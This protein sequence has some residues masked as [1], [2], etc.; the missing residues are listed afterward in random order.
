MQPLFYFFATA[1]LLLQSTRLLLSPQLATPSLGMLGMA[2][3]YLPPKI[4]LYLRTGLKYWALLGTL[5]DD[6]AVL[7]VA[8]GL[9]VAWSDFRAPA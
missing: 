7:I 3:P 8:C 4:G 1:E 6:L 5:L 2:L 9:C